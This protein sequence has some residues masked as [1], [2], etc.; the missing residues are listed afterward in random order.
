MVE[1]PTAVLAV[2]VVLLPSAMSCTAFTINTEHLCWVL[3]MLHRAVAFIST[4]AT[5]RMR[6]PIWFQTVGVFASGAVRFFHQFITLAGI[7]KVAC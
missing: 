4:P 1:R 2:R 5:F 7:L 3:T 6:P